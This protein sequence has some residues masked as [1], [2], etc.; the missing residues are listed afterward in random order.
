[1]HTSIF[2]NTEGNAQAKAVYSTLVFNQPISSMLFPDR[3]GIQ[4]ASQKEHL[5]NNDQNREDFFLNKM[6]FLSYKAVKHQMAENWV[7]LVGWSY[8][9]MVYL[10]AD[11]HPST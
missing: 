7:D 5:K 3:Q 4:N 6:S 11:S 1:M 8:A 10:S 2:A 9:K